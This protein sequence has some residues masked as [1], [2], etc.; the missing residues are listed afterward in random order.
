MLIR[1]C[2]ILQSSTKQSVSNNA[3]IGAVL[4]VRRVRTAEARKNSA[5]VMTLDPRL[6]E[7]E[8]KSR[9]WITIRSGTDL[10]FC[11]SMLKEMI[12]HKYY[13]RSF[14]AFIPICHF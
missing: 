4:T 5:R 2:N 11:L 3:S 7:T 9:E 6:S 14:Y 12:E 1:R 10:D 13:V 8:A